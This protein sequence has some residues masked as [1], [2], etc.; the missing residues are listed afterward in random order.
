MT[1]SGPPATANPLQQSLVQLALGTAFPVAVTGTLTLT[2]RGD[3]GADDATVQF[4]SGSRTLNF[5]IPANATQAAFTPPNPGLQMGTT[6]GVITLAARMQA[7]GADV[8]PNPPPSQ[9]IRVNPGPP[10]ISS[11]RATRTGNTLEVQATGYSST[12]EL[13]QA[14]FRFSASPGAQLQTTDLTVPVDSFFS[15]WYGSPAATA[16][17]SQFTYTQ[18]FTVQGSAGVQSITLTLTNRQGASQPAT[19]TLP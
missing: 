1:V 8:T 5:T 15:T 17:G 3:T 11:V 4:S 10:V 2:F 9:Q 19:A 16:T 18:Q 13:T 14:Q 12:R 7:A 6:A